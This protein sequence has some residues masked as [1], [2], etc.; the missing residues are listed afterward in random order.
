MKITKDKNNDYILHIP[1]EMIYCHSEHGM[2]DS[3]L[4]QELDGETIQKLF[5][6]NGFAVRLYAESLSQ[7]FDLGVFRLFIS[8]NGTANVSIKLWIVKEPT[9]GIKNVFSEIL[10]I[11]YN[12]NEYIFK[13]SYTGSRKS[14]FNSDIYNF[15]VS[16]QT[17]DFNRVVNIPA[18]SKE[19][20]E[21]KGY[22]FEYINL[23]GN[24]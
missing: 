2:V 20:W 9:S 7:K 23:S 22:A 1:S 3:G 13:I 14:L 19:F 4:Y 21:D 5:T 11:V 16:V 18:F 10:R 17:E 12:N 8:E 15:G 24:N 6:H